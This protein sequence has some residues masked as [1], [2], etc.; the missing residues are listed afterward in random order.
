[1]MN[2]AL[3]VVLATSLEGQQLGVPRKRLERCQRS[4]T[5]MCSAQ[6]PRL[7]PFGEHW[8][9]SCGT[10]GLARAA[11]TGASTAV[12]LRSMVRMGPPVLLVAEGRQVEGVERLTSTP[13]VGTGSGYPSADLVT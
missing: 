2:L 1:M 5:V 7:G 13:V 11:R 10:Y 9:H 8:P 12:D 3:A 6:Q 4:L